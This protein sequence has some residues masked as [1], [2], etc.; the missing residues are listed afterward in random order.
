MLINEWGNM[1]KVQELNKKK[2]KKF[3]SLKCNSNNELCLE[4]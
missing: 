1:K 4:F 3:N 2:R